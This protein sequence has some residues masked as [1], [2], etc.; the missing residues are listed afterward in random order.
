MLTLHASLL[1]ASGG[2]DSALLV[3]LQANGA[4]GDI[5]AQHPPWTHAI[6]GWMLEDWPS[7]SG[8][9]IACSGGLHIPGCL[10]LLQAGSFLR[11]PSNNRQ[12]DYLGYADFGCAVPVPS[13]QKHTT[14]KDGGIGERKNEGIGAEKGAG[15][16]EEEEMDEELLRVRAELLPAVV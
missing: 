12:Q 9:S 13:V 15:I 7:G 6:V 8:G 10:A 5:M 4:L 16:S 11:T 14:S 1:T 2:R 3:S